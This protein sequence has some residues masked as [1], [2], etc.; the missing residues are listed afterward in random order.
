VTTR[1]NF[2]IAGWASV[3][4]ALALIPIVVV[5][6]VITFF[7]ENR[8]LQILNNVL[9]L[10]TAA[11]GI[12]VLVAL[13]RLLHLHE[14]HAADFVVA[15]LIGG[16]VA[17]GAVELGGALV[18]QAETAAVVQL[19]VAMA[20][21]VI[22]AVLGVKMLPAMTVLPGPV[23]L[24]AYLTIV[25]GVSIATVVLIPVGIVASIA[26]DIALALM[27]FRASESPVATAGGDV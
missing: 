7:P 15:L 19:I 12:Y 8:L 21:G 27:F 2:T 16:I 26:G 3:L 4:S 17:G 20:M 13:R 11:L 6:V 24:F 1:A 23:K 5:T 9:S 25:S 18:G 22:S 10:V 14:V